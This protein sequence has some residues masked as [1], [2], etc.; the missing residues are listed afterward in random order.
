MAY[1]PLTWTIK[2]LG[3]LVKLK[4]HGYFLISVSLPVHR[5][6]KGQKEG[7]DVWMKL[8]IETAQEKE[9][10]MSSSGNDTL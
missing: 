5:V 8:Q 10:D 2:A 7:C 9:F 6:E 4:S 1:R 3:T